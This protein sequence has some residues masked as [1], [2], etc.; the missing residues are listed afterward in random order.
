MTVHLESKMAT[1][2]LISRY[3][4]QRGYAGKTGMT[5]FPSKIELDG[6]SFIILLLSSDGQFETQISGILHVIFSEM[7]DHRHQKGGKRN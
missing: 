2:C 1:K 6:T 5:H 3:C 4:T 7:V